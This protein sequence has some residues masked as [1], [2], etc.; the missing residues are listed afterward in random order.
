MSNPS[1]ALVR[2]FFAALSS[3]NVPDELLAPDMTAWTTTSGAA[4]RARYQGGIK[5][6][7]SITSGGLAYT[8]DSIT[9]EDDRAAAEVHSEGKLV[10]GETFKNVYVFVFRIRDGRIASVAEHFNPQPVEQKIIPLFKAMM[11]KAAK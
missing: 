10:N 8:V 1:H 11:A 9:A 6:L 4:D 7:S 3:G 5:M 2:K